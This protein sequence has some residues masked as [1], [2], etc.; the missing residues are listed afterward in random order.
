MAGQN[1]KY[2]FLDETHYAVDRNLLGIFSVVL[3]KRD[4]Q[5]PANWQ[6]YSLLLCLAQ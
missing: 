1:S 4:G 3:H 5:R 2:A 6:H